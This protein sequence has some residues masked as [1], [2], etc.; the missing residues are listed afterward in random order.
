MQEVLFVSKKY[1]NLQQLSK[2]AATF[3]IVAEVKLQQLLKL[4]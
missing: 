3:K 2:I 4:Q 1:L